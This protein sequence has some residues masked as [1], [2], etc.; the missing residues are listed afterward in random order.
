M[1]FNIARAKQDPVYLCSVQLRVLVYYTFTN[2]RQLYTHLLKGIG[3][4][5]R[6]SKL[7]SLLSFCNKDEKERKKIEL[8][9]RFTQNKRKK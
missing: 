3:G 8:N 2:T 4:A 1:Y 7:A 5:I 6:I 9:Q